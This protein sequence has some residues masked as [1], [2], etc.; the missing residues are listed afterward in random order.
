ME[1]LSGRKP[2]NEQ[3]LDEMYL[4]ASEDELTE[5]SLYFVI[6]VFKIPHLRRAFLV[7]TATMQVEFNSRR[8]VNK[9]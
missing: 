3:L 8:K 1:V 5:N 4:E 9:N 6:Q 2:N 7:G